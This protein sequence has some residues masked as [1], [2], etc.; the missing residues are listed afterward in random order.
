M[1][2]QMTKLV[3]GI[4]STPVTEPFSVQ[5]DQGAAFMPQRKRIDPFTITAKPEGQYPFQFSSCERC[6]R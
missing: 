5:K 3:N 6:V 4:K 1:H 2:N